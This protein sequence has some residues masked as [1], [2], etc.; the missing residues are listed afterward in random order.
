M[1]HNLNL[2]IYLSALLLIIGCKKEISS[3]D[4]TG[5]QTISKAFGGEEHGHLKQTKTYSSETAI[6]WMDM[7]L[8]LMRATT[9]V[10]NVAFSR[11]YVYSGIALYEA[12]VGGMPAYQTIAPQL[13]GLTGLPQT[14]SGLAYNWAAAAN[15]A[16]ALLNKQ[17]FPNATAANK[18][19]IDSLEA[20]LNSE[21]ATSTDE[22]ILTRSIAYGKDVAQRVFEWSATDGYQHASDPYIAP[23]GPGLWVPPSNPVPASST[24]YWG[25][26]RQIV[27]GS[28]EDAESPA[29]TAYSTDPSSAFYKMVKQVYDASQSLTANQT[30]MA[31]Y[32]RDVPGL[33]TP[34]HYVSI[35][36]QVLEHNNATLDMAALSYAL[37]G[38][39]VFDASISC[40]ASKYKYNLVRPITYIRTVLGHPSWTPLLATPAHPEYPS[41]HA[42]L[43]GAAAEAFEEIFG[44]NYS[45]TDHSYDYLGMA[46]RTYTS[47][48]AFAEEAANS[49]L[50]AGIHYQPSIDAGLLLG[51]TVAQ[52]VIGKLNFLK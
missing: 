10:A 43:S 47:F 14:V 23:Q 39:T 6:K 18:T 49:R 9:G 50:Y 24:P 44:N 2:L 36:K 25:N 3:S 12:V 17:F 51:R 19:A 8:R 28:G 21:F 34:G 37:S 32:W 29:P 31:L 15:A 45:Y 1:K 4:E 20:A 38:I 26:L 11:P 42:A 22:E 40:W 46:P 33:T 41:A 27:N 16:L 7:Q 35:L 13:N 52:N 48:R 5:Q 30:A